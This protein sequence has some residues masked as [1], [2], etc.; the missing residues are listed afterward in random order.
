MKTASVVQIQA[1]GPH[2][3]GYRVICGSQMHWRKNLQMWN[4]LKRMWGYI[5]LTE[6]LVLDKAH[7]HKNNIFS[8][9]EQNCH[10]YRIHN[11][12]QHLGLF[13]SHHQE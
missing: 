1:R 3:A 9:C 11:F 13:L 6:L 7:W 8:Y 12:I 5:C 10:N 4:L 2:V